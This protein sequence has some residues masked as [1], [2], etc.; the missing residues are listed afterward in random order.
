MTLVLTAEDESCL[1]S[2]PMFSGL[3]RKTLLW[4]LDSAIPMRHP[5]GGLLFSRGDPADRFFMVLAGRVDLLALN[6]GGAQSIIEVVSPGESFAEAAMF[7]SG[8]FPVTAQAI[9]GTRLLTVPAGPFLRRLAERPGLP[10]RLLAS[11]A[12]RQRQLMQEVAELK[13]RSP[14]QRLGLFLLGLAQSADPG[15]AVTLPLNK[16]QLAS[17]L[18]MT[19]ESLSRAM[20]RLRSLGVTTEG[21]EVRIADVGKLRRHCGGED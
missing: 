19:P 10:A 20:A 8:R 11:L 18:G 6:Q 12:R 7:A 15:Q 9:P 5:D 14:G 17:R 16:S 1:L 13:G 3:D 2:S 21:R 4:L